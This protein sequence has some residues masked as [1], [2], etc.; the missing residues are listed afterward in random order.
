MEIKPI[1]KA[2]ITAAGLGTRFLPATKALP[3]EMMPII[4]TPT[5]QYVLEE[6]IASGI[7]DVCII[8]SS[9]KSSIFNHFDYNVRLEQF[10]L[11][12]NKN[13]EYNLIHDIGNGANIFYI[14]QK[15]PLGLGHAIL[16]AES[17]IGNEPFAVILGDD[18]VMPEKNSKPAI[19]QCI[20]A[21]KKTNSSIVGVQKVPT[22]QI[23]KYGIIVPSKKGTS[24][25]TKMSGAVEKPNAAKAPSDLAILGRYVFKPEIFDHLKRVQKDKNGEIQLT[26]AINTLSKKQ[27]IYAYTFTGKRYDIGSPSGYV[28]A[29]IDM[30]LK[31][32]DIK[33]KI[34]DHI[35]SLKI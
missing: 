6:C 18:I 34:I 16:C 10:L 33:D 17:F 8:T 4:D 31:H 13:K 7:T 11:S 5:I 20:Q 12:K 28:I 30:S 15:Q 19:M 22:S 3:K 25:I 23:E 29:T 27:G 9:D 1:R 24:T 14:R 35:R 2:I 26:S 32:N 21:Y